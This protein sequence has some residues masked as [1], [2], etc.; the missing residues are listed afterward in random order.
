VYYPVVLLSKDDTSI[1]QTISSGNPGNSYYATKALYFDSTT[2]LTNLTID[3]LRI[4]N[5][6]AGVVI[7]GRTNHVL[8]NVQIAKCANGIV[9]TNADFSLRNA[10]FSSVLTNFSGS[11]ATGHVEHLT[12]DV[13]AWLNKDIGANLFLTNCILSAVTN[14]GSCATQSVAMVS[15]SAGVFQ[16]VGAGAYYLTN[17]S[18]YRD[19]GTANINPSLLAQLGQKTT[20]PPIPV[21]SSNFNVLTTLGPTALRD[22]DTPD[23]GYHYDPMDYVFS[24]VNINTNM[25]ISAGTAIGWFKPSS[26]TWAIHLADKTAIAFNGTLEAPDYFVR[27]ST[28]QE[29]NTGW[30]TGLSGFGI[31][32]SQN[33]GSGNVALSSEIDMNFTTMTGFVGYDQQFRDNNGYLTVRA[34]NS[35]LAG[36]NVVGYDISLYLTNC[37]MDNQQVGQIAGLAGNEVYLRNCTLHNGY[38]YAQN[39]AAIQTTVRDSAFDGVELHLAGSYSNSPT[40]THYDYNAYPNATDPFPIG[41]SYDQKSVSFN[42]QVGPGG[43]FYLPSNSA[44][45]NAGDTNADLL[46]LYHFTTQTNQ[47]KE[48]N[49]LVDI[50]Y[51]YVALNAA[52]TAMDTDGDGLPD[53]LEDANGDGI[54]DSGDPFDWKTADANGS[55]G[56]T[57][58]FSNGM[59][60]LIL[61]PKPTSQIP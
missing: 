19:A 10:L 36:G 15:S 12:S 49:S 46:G 2:A 23:L 53:Y 58:V 26:T 7:N 57:A 24:S 14:L 35:T 54:Y 52:G 34:N 17:N 1:G 47:I 40:Y 8:S 41:G 33:A 21:L 51:H 9:A 32:G 38:F 48:T 16:T 30:G 29:G 55:G 39:S 61:E 56:D 43:R 6:Q 22:K 44:L 42:W 28:A 59:S 60:L 3:N 31:E 25:T 18:P 37:L 13:S 4:L 50:G 27:T 5:A 11:S 45:I 20:Y